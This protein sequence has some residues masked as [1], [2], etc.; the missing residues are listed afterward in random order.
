MQRVLI[1]G[2]R[3]LDESN[4]LASPVWALLDGLVQP[5]IPEAPVELVEGGALHGADAIAREWLKRSPYADPDVVSG[6]SF[7]A[8]WD[9]CVS[10]CQP[11]H[12][13][14]RA[15]GSGDYC[16][17]AGFRRNEQ[18][19]RY[20]V[21]ARTLGATVQAWGFV[22]KPLR[23]S[24]G[25]H[26]MAMRLWSHRVPFQIVQVVTP[27]AKAPRNVSEAVSGYVGAM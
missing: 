20:L 25:S 12:R 8:E 5:V 1:F 2:S 22:T 21:W 17:V 24:H 11:G 16:P 7:P 6:R 15:N 19:A 13:K 23:D 3:D 18:M 10:D 27:P 4:P 26:D 14:P 9:V